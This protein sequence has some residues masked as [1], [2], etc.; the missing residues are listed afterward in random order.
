MKGMSMLNLSLPRLQ[1]QDV[2]IQEKALQF[3]GRSHTLF[4]PLLPFTLFSLHLLYLY[5]CHWLPSIDL[6]VNRNL[7]TKD[8]KDSKT[9]CKVQVQQN[10]EVGPK[11]KVMN[12]TTF[13]FGLLRLAP[14]APLL[15][16][17]FSHFHFWVNVT[18][19]TCLSSSGLSS[20]R[21]FLSPIFMRSKRSLSTSSSENLLTESTALSETEIS[22]R[23]TCEGSP[24]KRNPFFLSLERSQE[25]KTMLVKKRS[26]DMSLDSESAAKS[27]CDSNPTLFPDC[28][29]RKPEFGRLN[30]DNIFDKVSFSCVW[31]KFLPALVGTWNLQNF[32][33]LCDGSW[34]DLHGGFRE[35]FFLVSQ[36][37]LKKILPFSLNVGYDSY[38]EEFRPFPHHLFF[39]YG[40]N[41]FSIISVKHNGD[42]LI[43]SPE[44]WV[45]M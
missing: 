36:K 17:R 14:F 39:A 42:T 3:I 34:H 32:S 10:F 1:E 38:A 37:F 29:P 22:A 30:S 44:V 40:N 21:K 13:A 43:N 23:S 27:L 12:E 24:P 4:S 31:H 41:Q 25:Q 9:V 26:S 8:S 5:F 15:L 33:R 16:I 45:K 2:R 6:L 11:W 18:F 28:A 7:F 20:P 35:L 19:L